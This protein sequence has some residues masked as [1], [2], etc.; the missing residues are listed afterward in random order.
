V[1]P[2]RQQL[3]E[4]SHRRSNTAQ[5]VRVRLALGA[6]AGFQQL[7]SRD[8][9]DDHRQD[10]GSPLTVSVETF[11]EGKAVRGGSAEDEPAQRTASMETIC[12]TRT[13]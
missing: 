11:I 13:T 5:R 4:Q 3:G 8:D 2:V 6:A 10:D 1:R 7:A 9:D 12:V